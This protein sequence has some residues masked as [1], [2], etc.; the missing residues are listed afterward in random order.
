M[1]PRWLA[2][3]L[4]LLYALG[5]LIPLVVLLRQSLLEENGGSLTLENYGAV[6]TSAAYRRALLNS[7]WIALA[8]TLLALIL[9]FPVAIYIERSADP[10]RHALAVALSIPLSLPGIVIGFFVIL[11]FGRTGLVPQL[12]L[13]LTGERQLSLAYTF[14]GML[15]GYLY[16]QIPRV[17]LVLRGAVAAL[18]QEVIEVSRTLGATPLQVYLH[19]LLPALLPALLGAASVSLATAFGAFG[20]AATLSRGFRVLPL[21][22]AASFTESFQPGRAASLSI[23]LTLLTTAILVGL[24]QVAEQALQPQRPA[25][26]SSRGPRP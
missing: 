12:F 9:C 25:A 11:F 1:G 20:T 22:I 4:V 7:I 17:V 6:V 23:V 15:L 14:G 21:E 24:G 19:V 16:F 10:H 5:L 13:L 8:S 18:P 2:A 3:P 26:G